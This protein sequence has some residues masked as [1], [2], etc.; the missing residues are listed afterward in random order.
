MNYVLIVKQEDM[1]MGYYTCMTEV[2]AEIE[3]SYNEWLSL[4]GDE[5]GLVRWREDFIIAEILH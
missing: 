4:G 2:N 3:N 5:C 1:V